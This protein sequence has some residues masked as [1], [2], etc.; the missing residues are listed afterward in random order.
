ME[1]I[2][3]QNKHK[4]GVISTDHLKILYTSTLLDWDDEKEKVEK[5]VGPGE[6]EDWWQVKKSRRGEEEG[7]AKVTA[8]C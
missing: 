3:Y 7:G 2:Q 6:A 4:N 5:R 8:R 1:V